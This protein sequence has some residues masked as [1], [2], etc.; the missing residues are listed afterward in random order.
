MQ[1]LGN[2][3]YVH[4]AQC[5]VVGSLYLGYHWVKKHW[6]RLAKCLEKAWNVSAGEFRKLV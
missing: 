5:H 3:M 2:F 4:H 6:N 1:S